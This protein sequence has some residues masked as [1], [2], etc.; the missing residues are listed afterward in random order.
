ME[1]GLARRLRSVSLSL[2]HTPQGHHLL[3]RPGCLCCQGW[4]WAPQSRVP[5]KQHAPPAQTQD[6]SHEIR[7][8]A[9]SLRFHFISTAARL[10]LVCWTARGVGLDAPP[11]CTLPL[12]PCGPFLRPNSPAEAC[13]SCRNTQ[14]LSS[15]PARAQSQLG[16]GQGLAPAQQGKH[17][18]QK[19]LF[20]FEHPHLAP[21]EKEREQTGCSNK[22]TLI[23]IRFLS[24]FLAVGVG[25]SRQTLGLGTP[26]S[27]WGWALQGDSG[28][29]H[30]RETLGLGIPGDSG[31]GHSRSLWVGHSREALGVDRARRRVPARRRIPGEEKS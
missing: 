9:W 20:Y 18:L 17:A 7:V 24:F 23:Q 28:V 25:H 6:A 3:C 4:S 8:Q 22:D 15:Q 10:H 31:V 21:R 1:P 30:S 27:V 29:G 2:T 26:G 5:A 13:K 11:L 19:S 12:C 14:K 16:G